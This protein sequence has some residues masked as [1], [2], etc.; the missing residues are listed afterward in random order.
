MD[1]KSASEIG[2]RL[3]AI[4]AHDDEDL[5]TE[6][7]QCDATRSHFDSF[8]GY[9]QERGRRES[10]V[11]GHR[12]RFWTS[13]QARKGEQREPLTVVEIDDQWCIAARV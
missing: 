11:N 13:V 10:V 6:F 3:L 12:V 2:R 5:A 9:H 8:G 4:T 7:E 1:Q